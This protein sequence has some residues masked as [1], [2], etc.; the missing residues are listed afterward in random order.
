MKLLLISFTVFTASAFAK[1]GTIE[2]S[3]QPE[4]RA[5]VIGAVMTEGTAEE[6][7][8]KLAKIFPAVLDYLEL[9]KAAPQSAPFAR[10][11][12]APAPGMKFEAGF[13][14]GDDVPAPCGC[15]ELQEIIIAESEKVAVVHEGPYE[16]TGEA[17]GAIHAWMEQNGYENNGAPWETY[18]NDPAEVAAEDLITVVHYPIKKAVR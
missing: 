11:Y 16:N 2:M 15:G 1:L 14:V 12:G 18:E 10:F 9:A 8:E 17:Y 7:G 6:I 13:I 4:T 5:I 3:H